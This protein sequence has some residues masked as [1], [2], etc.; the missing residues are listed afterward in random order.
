MYPLYSIHTPCISFWWSSI[1]SSFMVCC[2]LFL[3]LCC[4]SGWL[5]RYL[6][7]SKS[8]QNAMSNEKLLKIMFCWWFFNHYRPDPEQPPLLV[9]LPHIPQTLDWVFC[10]GPVEKPQEMSKLEK[11]CYNLNCFQSLTHPRHVEARMRQLEPFPGGPVVLG[12]PQTQ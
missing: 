9:A 7:V 5:K 3:N 12:Q 11:D 2:R 6:R 10:H 4:I 8:P 1:L